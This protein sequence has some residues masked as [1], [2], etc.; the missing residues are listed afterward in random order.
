M[1]EPITIADRALGRTLSLVAAGVIGVVACTLAVKLGD[2]TT[3]KLI[4]VGL[5]ALVVTIAGVTRQPRRVFLFTWIVALTYNRQYLSF[6]AVLGDHGSQGLYWIPADLIFA[7]L[8]VLW[9][10]EV[11]V[12]KRIRRVNVSSLP[13]WLLPFVV[14]CA[15]STLA[16]D[17]VS[18]SA[19]EYVRI[20]KFAFIVLYVRYTFGRVEWWICVAALGLAVL[21]QAGLGILQ[22]TLNVGAGLRSLLGGMEVD[23]AV[24]LQLM[25]RRQHRAAGTMAHPNFLGP[26]LLLLVPMF[27]ALWMTLRHRLMRS[28]CLGVALVGLAGVACTL[29]R[30]PWAV[31]ALEVV[32]IMAVLTWRGLIGARRALGLVM[33]GGLILLVVAMPFAPALQ[34]R[35]HGDLKEAYGFRGRYNRAALQMWSQSPLLGIGLNNFRLHLDRYAPDLE[36][37]QA[38]GDDTAKQFGLRSTAPVHNFYLLI[39]CESGVVGLGAFLVLV[40]GAVCTGL[41]AAWRTDGAWAAACCGL[42][43]GIVGQLL[44]QT[45]DFSLWIDPAWYTFALMIALAG[46]A[47]ALAREPAGSTVDAEA[48]IPIPAAVGL[49]EDSNRFD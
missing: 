28:I 23:E 29:S 49:S 43:V 45:M 18:W 31:A 22:V 5:A 44:Q 30:L 36:A 8:L 20:L 11:V 25:G 47:P 24:T 37:I 21:M 32:A 33:L 17:R 34:E 7:V 42:L 40:V 26:Y 9:V 3:K 10:G 16:A 48:M 35:V 14:A 1:N 15:L 12:T 27:I 13:W 19:F 41:R 46:T 38:K 39:L 6:E 4:A 2:L